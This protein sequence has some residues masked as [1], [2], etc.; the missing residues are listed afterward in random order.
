MNLVCY[1]YGADGAR[2][3]ILTNV[4]IKNKPIPRRDEMVVDDDGNFWT[5]IG[6]GFNYPADQIIIIVQ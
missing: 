3:E 1:Q 6:V 2:R 5:V 4:N